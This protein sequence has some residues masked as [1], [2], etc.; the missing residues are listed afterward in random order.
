MK[1]IILFTAIL[2]STVCTKAQIT[3]E[4]S[5]PVVSPRYGW[6]F[7]TD[8]GDN[9][10]K[11]VLH[12]YYTDIVSLYNLDHTLYLNIQ[13]P[14]SSDTGIRYSIGYI[15]N[16]LFDCDSSNLEYALLPENS[17]Y[18]FKVYRTDG[19]ELFSKDSVYAWWCYG[20]QEASTEIRPVVNTPEGAK[21]YLQ[22][23]WSNPN[24][25]LVYGLCGTLPNSISERNAQKFFVKVYPNPAT[26]KI[27]FRIAPPD[28]QSGYE[29][30]IFNSNFQFLKACAVTEDNTQI[31]LDDQSFSS[32]IYFYALKREQKI[33]QTGK[34]VIQK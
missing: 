3:Y 30:Q 16:R 24:R 27:N 25:V 21:L 13:I 14:I 26:H 4:Q 5:Y 6:F 22:D 19:A 29:L 31:D 1:K 28:S 7:V 8:I 32:G 2:V 17:I 18:P 34:F 12:D 15:T 20:C 10:Y 33:F 11:Y 9:N 23:T